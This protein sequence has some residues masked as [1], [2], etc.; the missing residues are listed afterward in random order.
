LNEVGPPE[1]RLWPLHPQPQKYETLTMWVERLAA[2]Y[3]V[4]FRFFCRHALGLPFAEMAGMCN[5]PSEQL[6]DRLAAGTGVPTTRLR[7]M[8]I[9][10]LIGQFQKELDVYL[11]RLEPEFAAWLAERSWK[12]AQGYKSDPEYWRVIALWKKRKAAP[13]GHPRSAPSPE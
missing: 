2:A 12:S 6:L 1:P 10:S 3:G 13:A 7:E 9:G 8:T 4:S 5:A 11:M